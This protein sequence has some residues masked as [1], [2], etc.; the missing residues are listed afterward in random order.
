LPVHLTGLAVTVAAG[1]DEQ[2]QT[3]S[4][5]TQKSNDQ[6][7]KGNYQ[8]DFLLYI[9]T[10]KAFLL[11]HNSS[12][13]KKRL[14]A[15]SRCSAKKNSWMKKNNSTSKLFYQTVS[16]KITLSVPCALKIN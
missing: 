9:I 4:A 14:S 13:S 8:H 3:L 15:N 5:R 11:C 2:D 12:D 1:G 7:D 10:F 6:G 16:T